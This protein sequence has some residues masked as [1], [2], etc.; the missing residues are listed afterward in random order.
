[1]AALRRCGPQDARD[2]RRCRTH[3]RDVLAALGRSFC[4]EE[5][6]CRKEALFLSREIRTKVQIFNKKTRGRDRASE[7]ASSMFSLSPAH[8]RKQRAALPRGFALRQ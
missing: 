6:T 7:L 3:Y 2:G 4:E 5:K 8:L 1:L